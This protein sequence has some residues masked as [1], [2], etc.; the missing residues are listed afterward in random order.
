MRSLVPVLAVVLLAS[1]CGEKDKLKAVAERAVS[2]PGR[3]TYVSGWIDG[4]ES[5][6]CVWIVRGSQ[7]PV[8]RSLAAALSG[9]GFALSCQTAGETVELHG[10][11]KDMRV[12]G[13]IVPPGPVY[14]FD[15]RPM[16]E[17]LARYG[18]PPTPPGAV[19]VHLDVSSREATGLDEQTV[20]NG[21]A[22]SS[23]AAE[24]RTLP[25][26]VA[27]WNTGKAE[28]R[29]AVAKRRPRDAAHVGELREIR[30]GGCVFT[31]HAGDEWMI[32]VARWRG[33]EL[34]WEPTGL[35]SG[36]WSPELA[37]SRP[38]NVDV[39]PDGRLRLRAR[40]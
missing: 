30:G 38:D 15:G 26:C 22:C 37:R 33:R 10:Y 6:G 29:A 27:A 9:Q 31:F 2:Q 17:R 7:M 36:E 35:Q 18:E 40:R 24:P 11:T 5:Y 1:A 23:P 28:L 25:D 19:V 3:C 14:A 12:S 39:R 20:A 4:P 16:P 21:I 34:A 8:T 32:A 13:R